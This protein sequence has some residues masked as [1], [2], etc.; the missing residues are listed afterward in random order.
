[1]ESGKDRGREEKNQKNKDPQ[2]G[3]SSLIERK[4]TALV[5]IRPKLNFKDSPIITIA[6]SYVVFTLCQVLL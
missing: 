2:K 5:P 3:K 6:K 1:M 4:Q